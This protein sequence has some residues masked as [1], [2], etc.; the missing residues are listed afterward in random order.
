MRKNE[1]RKIT[2]T[3]VFVAIA[4]VFSLITKYV[5]GLN[6]EMP[7]GGS[8]F[9]FPMIPIVLLGFILGVQYGVLGGILYGVI[10]VLLDGGLYHW[11]SLFFDYLIA[12][13]LLGFTG[14]FKKYLFS[15]VKFVLV[16]L[17]V[18]F[19]RYLSHSIGGVLIFGEFAPEGMN[20]W[21]YSFIVY[22]APYMLSAT[23]F[24]ALVASLLRKKIIILSEQYGLLGTTD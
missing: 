20:P 10:S 7:Q 2:F 5:P 22:N 16:I 9:G 18:G 6:L 21:F 13:G 4:F 8:I 24:T 1:I 14:L 3:S 11:G 23:F 12:F 19:L 17:F 15:P